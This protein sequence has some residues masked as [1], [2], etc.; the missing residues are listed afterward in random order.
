MVMKGR[1]LR[2]GI[3]GNKGIALHRFIE[4]FVV[5]PTLFVRDSLI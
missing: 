5:H 1:K 4:E 2:G 3:R